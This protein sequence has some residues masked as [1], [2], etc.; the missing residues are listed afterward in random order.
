VTFFVRLA[1]AAAGCA[2]VCAV[3][4]NTATPVWGPIAVG[5][6]GQAC[7]LYASDT[8]GPVN[9]RVADIGKSGVPPLDDA[10]A[11]MVKRILDVKGDATSLWF[12]FITN[13][14]EGGLEFIVFDASDFDDQPE[15]CT[16]APLGYPV[17]NLRCDCYYESGEE[18][19]LR[20][21]DGEARVP[22]PWLTP[23]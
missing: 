23:P 19:R 13:P 1:V 10:Q 3:R 11:A 8:I 21:G 22:K 15:P 7:H 12:S 6:Y 4:G 2:L 5:R 9:Y 14:K 20:S 18:A 16:Y 17:L